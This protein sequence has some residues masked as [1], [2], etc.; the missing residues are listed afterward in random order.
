MKDQMVDPTPWKLIIGA[1]S[2]LLGGGGLLWWRKRT[3]KEL[4]KQ[5]ATDTQ[6]ANA[7]HQI[8]VK[9]L[10]QTKKDQEGFMK[11]MANTFSDIV[12]KMSDSQAKTTQAIIGLT[13]VLTDS[14]KEYKESIERVHNRITDHENDNK[15]DFDKV[16]DDFVHVAHCES[17]MKVKRDLGD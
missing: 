3:D 12:L 5:N 17:K 2:T 16:K 1:V 14:Q 8:E 9:F 10:E 13:K 15:K 11:D 4:D 6:L 7:I